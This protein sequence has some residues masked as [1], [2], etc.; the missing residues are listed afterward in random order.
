MKFTKV[1]SVFTLFLAVKLLTPEC[2]CEQLSNKAHPHNN[3]SHNSA[4]GN[5]NNASSNNNSAPTNSSSSNPA[6]GKSA[7]QGTPSTQ[8]T[9]ATSAKLESQGKT[10]PAPTPEPVT[11]PKD[12]GDKAIDQIDEQ[13][14]KKKKSKKLCLIS[15]AA[16]TLALLVGGALGFGIY[17]SK[18]GANTNAEPTINDNT[19]PT[20]E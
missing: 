19:Q 9:S 2:Y 5:K 6:S 17:K 13:I 8:E 10:V 16:T 15:A 1:C 11:P 3:H 7:N 18:K 20:A 14:E 4:S 12:N